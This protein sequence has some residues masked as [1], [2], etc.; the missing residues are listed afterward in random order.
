LLRVTVSVLDIHPESAVANCSQASAESPYELVDEYIRYSRALVRDMASDATTQFN[1]TSLA[2][3]F[4]VEPVNAPL[5]PGIGATSVIVT[6][7]V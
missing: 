2:Y 4:K 1:V 7:F 3:G 5:F 6:V